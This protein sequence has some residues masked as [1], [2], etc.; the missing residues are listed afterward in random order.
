M[1]D[2]T[3][4]VGLVQVACFGF[5]TQEAYL[6]ALL[7]TNFRLPNKNILVSSQQRFLPK[8]VHGVFTLRELGFNI[9][10]TEKTHAFLKRH[11]VHS[12]LLNYPNPS[13]PAGTTDP[14]GILNHLRD[15]KIDLVI[16]M[17]NADSAQLVR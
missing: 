3:V 15:G 6:K 8:F 17:P 2:G 10:A 4:S 1:R 9:F 13:L 16:N 12:T 5:N 11:N 7:S 14:A